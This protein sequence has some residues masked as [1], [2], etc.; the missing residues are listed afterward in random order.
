MG[1]RLSEFPKLESYKLLNI[2]GLSYDFLG[3]VVLSEILASSE[4]WKQLCVNVVAPVVLWFHTVLPVGALG[5]CFRWS[6]SRTCPVLRSRFEFCY[7]IRGLLNLSSF[8]SQ[9]YCDTSAVCRSKAR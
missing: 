1:F 2:V 7:W 3:V 6:T 4:K 5:G 9:R 8:D